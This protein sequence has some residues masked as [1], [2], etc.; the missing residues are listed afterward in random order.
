MPNIEEDCNMMIQFLI[1]HNK[2]GEELNIAKVIAITLKQHSLE[3]VIKNL[4]S[5]SQTN[6]IASL[7]KTVK[8]LNENTQ[9]QKLPQTS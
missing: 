4:E 5:R 8:K 9:N 2:P 3:E 7:L 1:D 6:I